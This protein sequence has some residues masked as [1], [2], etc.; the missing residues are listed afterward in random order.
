MWFTRS[1]VVVPVT[2]PFGSRL[3]PWIVSCLSGKAVVNRSIQEPTTAGAEIGL[4][5][6]CCSEAE[7][8]KLVDLATDNSWRKDG[9]EVQRMIESSSGYL[10]DPGTDSSRSRDG[11]EVQQMIKQQW[12]TG[13]FRHWQQLEQK[14]AGKSMQ[15]RLY[16]DPSMAARIKGQGKR[17]VVVKKSRS[18]TAGRQLALVQGTGFRNWQPL[19]TGP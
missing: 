10:V 7:V 16:C 2:F 8:V 4:K 18:A 6:I 5:S 12:L 15:V 13:G 9:L 14:M 19:S 3:L 1:C 11:M 17:C